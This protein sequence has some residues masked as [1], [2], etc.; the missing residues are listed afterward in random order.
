MCGYTAKGK[1]ASLQIHLLV[2]FLASSKDRKGNQ[3]Q[4]KNCINWLILWQFPF[5]SIF[6]FFSL[7]TII[8]H[9]MQR[10][11]PCFKQFLPLFGHCH[12]WDCTSPSPLGYFNL[13]TCYQCL[14]NKS[15]YHWKDFHEITNILF[16]FKERKPESKSGKEFLWNLRVIINRFQGSFLHFN[17]NIRLRTV[18]NFP[19]QEVFFG[20]YFNTCSFTKDFSFDGTPGN[21][22]IH[23]CLQIPQDLTEEYF[24]I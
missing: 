23:K 14:N 1:N 4:Q 13:F 11:T 17:F 15:W 6:L 5:N 22:L 16:I 3:T 24:F 19:D 21:K 18:S 2:Y 9:K 12:G 20:L 7:I 10:F 8:Q